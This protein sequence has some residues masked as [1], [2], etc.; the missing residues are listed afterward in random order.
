MKKLLFGVLA[1]VG[2]R[3]NADE[4]TVHN[5]TGHPVNIVTAWWNKKIGE[6]SLTLN[7]DSLRAVS[8]DEPA[9]FERPAA[10]GDKEAWLLAGYSGRKLKDLEIKS[11]ENITKN[12][13]LRPVLNAQLKNAVEKIGIEIA[14][15]NEFSIV[16]AGEDSVRIQKEAPKQEVPVPAPAAVIPAPAA[17]V[18]VMQEVAAPGQEEKEGFFAKA[19]SKGRTLLKKAKQAVTPAAEENK[20]FNPAILSSTH[21]N[22]VLIINGLE[23][24]EGSSIYVRMY[25]H[26]N[27][28]IFASRPINNELPIKIEPNGYSFLDNG[29]GAGSWLGST[30]F[31]LFVS[32]KEDDLSAGTDIEYGKRSDQIYEGLIYHNEILN[33]ALFGDNRR[34]RA[35]RFIIGKPIRVEVNAIDAPI[36]A[37]MAIYVKDKGQEGDYILA[38]PIVKIK[39]A[40]GVDKTKET[41]PINIPVEQGFFV[42]LGFFAREKIIA[43]GHKAQF[44][45][46]FN[47]TDFPFGARSYLPTQ[48][49]EYVVYAEDEGKIIPLITTPAAYRPQEEPETWWER[50]IGWGVA[51]VRPH[52][53]K[54]IKK[55]VKKSLK[56]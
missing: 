17:Q 30:A 2:M 49:S 20:T 9:K 26:I 43:V 29:P 23:R 39:T 5:M 51:K 52:A 24:G 13:L 4:I 37:Y 35:D 21:E 11:A 47:P 16:P 12:F 15:G 25:R 34:F 7:A 10:Q 22:R 27:E 44:E 32:T 6:P 56:E 19:V 45:A 38:T 36:E 40:M 1:L 28:P 3:M 46:R 14:S 31:A 53:E 50:A 55:Q 18:P 33:I 8:T 54:A 48:G 41:T 42:R